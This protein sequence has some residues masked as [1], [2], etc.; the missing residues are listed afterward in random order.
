MPYRAP[1]LQ[2]TATTAQ[3]SVDGSIPDTATRAQRITDIAA[4]RA[5]DANID[6][7]VGNMQ[8]ADA[9]RAVPRARTDNLNEQAG[10]HLTPNG[11]VVQRPSIFSHRTNR[12]NVNRA[13]NTFTPAQ[14]RA[15]QTMVAP[16]T[17]RQRSIRDTVNQHFESGG[18]ISALGPNAQDFVRRTDGAIQ[19]AERENDRNHTVY[20]KL[21]LPSG[22]SKREY[23]A[24]LR[25]HPSARQHLM[26]YTRANHDLNKIEGGDD[27][28]YVQ[29]ETSR[30]M[31]V[32]GNGETGHVLPRGVELEFVGAG[33]FDVDNGQG[34]TDRKTIVQVREVRQNERTV[35]RS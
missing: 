26:G 24:S 7:S 22:T 35:A 8:H 4:I 6:A 23:L 16:T 20:T 3:Q 30:G 32:G 29:I 18:A 15:V 31:Y 21:S 10:R 12:R 2:A 13:I 25:A 19:K 9:Q 28:V 11:E 14:E 34:G 27:D 5:A 17:A 33:E 1:S